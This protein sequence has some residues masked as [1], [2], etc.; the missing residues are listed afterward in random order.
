MFSLLSS[1]KWSHLPNAGGLYDQNP[2]LLDAI[3]KIF[4]AQA[5]YE[6]EQAEKQRQKQGKSPRVAGRRR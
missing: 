3:R 4:A 1:M 2:E 6:S 5:Q